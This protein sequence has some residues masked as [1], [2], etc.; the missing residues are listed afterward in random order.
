MANKPAQ[1]LSE[2]GLFKDLAARITDASLFRYELNNPL[3]TD[4]ALKIRYIYIPPD[5]GPA[6]IGKSSEVLAFPIGTVLVKTFAYPQTFEKPN[7]N[8]RFIETRLL[9]HKKEGWKAYPYI[10][11]V[12]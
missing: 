4:Y 2:Y 5:A 12:A 8:I 11:N 1:K 9:I 3:F 10:W 7:E 6:L